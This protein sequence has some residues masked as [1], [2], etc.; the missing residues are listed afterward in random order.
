MKTEPPG[1]FLSSGTIKQAVTL[2]VPPV[3]AQTLS[4]LNAVFYTKKS[5]T[6]FFYARRG[7]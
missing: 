7:V 2:K 3:S 6:S 4:I 1:V 5:K